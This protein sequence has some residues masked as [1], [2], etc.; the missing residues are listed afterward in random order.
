MQKFIFENTKLEGLKLVTPFK[1]DDNRGYF[2]KSFERDIFLENG[3]DI[4][5]SEINESQSSKGVLRGLHFQLKYPQTKLVRVVHGNI[6]DVAVD[7]RKNSPTFGRWQ[8][9]YLS[10]DKKSMLYISKGFAHGFLT[11]SDKAVVTYTCDGKYMMEYDSG[12]LWDDSD[13]AI[14]WPLHRV[15]KIILSEKD[16]LLKRLSDMH[17]VLF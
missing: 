15:D 16:K 3:I 10:G 4:N 6:F 1:A 7:L 14:E 9:F 13:I 2:L 5:V 11:L 12:I 8:G 17:D